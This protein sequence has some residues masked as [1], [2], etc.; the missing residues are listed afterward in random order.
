MGAAG[1][2]SRNPAATPRVL[3]L[4]ATVLTLG[5]SNVLGWGMRWLSRNG[6]ARYV[7]PALLANEC[8]GAWRV[9]AAGSAAGWW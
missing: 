3:A 2:P 4:L 8:F 9:Y 7:L 6:L 1:A 5:T